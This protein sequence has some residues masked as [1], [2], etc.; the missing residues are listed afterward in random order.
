MFRKIPQD[1][2][3]NKLP[4]ASKIVIN[5]RFLSHLR[6]GIARFS[7]EMCRQI[8]EA[9]LPATVLVPKGTVVPTDFPLPFYTCGE[10]RSHFWEQL[11]LPRE[12][13]RLGKPPLLCFSGVG[14]VLYTNK[15]MTIHDLAFLRNP[16][17]FSPSYSAYY[18]TVTPVSARRSKAI[19]TVSS[20][21]KREI[22]Q[23]ISGKLPEIV[24]IPNGVSELGTQGPSSSIR[25]K[26]Y[27][28]SVASLD[29]RKNQQRLIDA[30]ICE[31]LVNYEL[32]LVGKC[33]KHF[34]VKLNSESSA[35]KFLGH[36]SDE[37]LAV[38]YSGCSAF[39]YPSLY[40]GFGIPPLEAMKYGAPTLVSNIPSLREVCGRASLYVDPLSVEEIR[41]GLV[42]LL[43][44]STLRDCL[45]ELGRERVRQ[46][47]W[48]SSGAGLITLVK[49][50]WPPMRTVC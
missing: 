14:P 47:S 40:E 11:D 19:V 24:V 16:R 4:L 35:V 37:E 43:R 36:V 20:F 3:K 39:A 2:S 25:A 29:P 33:T 10:F 27:V 46:F 49:R 34:R 38:L 17:W 48:S 41:A 7:W 21:S 31:S 5:G 15:V 45:R 8:A 6:D 13:V 50:I 28:L 12:L 42:K 30:F 44:D 32:I 1:L 22:E 9:G 23:L 26:P 18:R